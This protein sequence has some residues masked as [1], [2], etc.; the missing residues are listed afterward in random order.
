MSHMEVDRVV[1]DR[2]PAARGSKVEKGDQVLVMYERNDCQIG[3]AREIDGDHVA[4]F[5]KQYRT[6][7]KQIAW[8]RNG[9]LVRLKAL[10]LR[11]RK[12]LETRPKASAQRILLEFLKGRSCRGFK[13]TPCKNLAVPCTLCIEAIENHYRGVDSEKLKAALDNSYTSNECV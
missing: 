2:V 1:L 6:K 3:E 10:P 5:F 11:M 8:L 12:A 4:V 9:C 7:A 13:G